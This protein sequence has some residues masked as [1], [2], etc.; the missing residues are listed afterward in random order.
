MKTKTRKSITKRFKITKNGKVLRRA[1]G[2][3][4]FRAKKPG[5]IIREKRKWVEVSKADSKKI[6]KILR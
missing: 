4:H 1:T 5:K 6:K 2:Q 3:D